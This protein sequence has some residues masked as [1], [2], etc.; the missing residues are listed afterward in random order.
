MQ[1]GAELG[2]NA[3]ELAEC[4]G[5]LQKIDFLFRE[6]E[7]RFDQHAQVND[8]LHQFVNAIGEYAGE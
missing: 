5:F 4:I 8:L 7:R 6:I 2:L 1:H 3:I